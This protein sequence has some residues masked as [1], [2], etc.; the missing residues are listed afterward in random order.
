MVNQLRSMSDKVE[1]I[2]RMLDEDRNQIGGPCG[3]SNNL[4]PIH[5]Q[6][7]QLETFRN[8]TLH[9]AR[10]TARDGPQGE[11]DLQT[12]TKWFERLDMVAQEY[13]DWLWAIAGSIVDC[14]RQ[15]NSGTVVRLLKVIE[16]EG[17]EDQKAV[18]LKLLRRMGGH[19]DAASKFR[20]MQGNARVIKNYR[21]KLLDTISTSIKRSFTEAIEREQGDHLA[22]L[23]NLSWIYKDILRIESDV[24]PLFPEDYEIYAFYVKA[25]HKFL[26]ESLQQIVNQAPE[27]SVLLRMH[28]WIKEY[29]S[30]MKELEIPNAWLQPPLLD[31]KSQ[32][33]IEDYVK[34]IV[35]KIDE[36]TVNLM[37][38]E[39][40]DFSARDTP[41]EMEADGMYG[42]Q[43]AVILFQMVNQQVDLAADSG[44]GAV[45]ARVVSESGRVMRSTQT[46]WMRLLDVEYKRQ[47][48]RPQ[49]VPP[50]LVEYVVALANDQLKCADYAE[51]LSTRLEPLVS[52]KYKSVIAEKL[53]EAIDGY[54]DVAKKCTQVLIDL[55]FNDLKTVQKSLFTQAWYTDTLVE[56][57]V[58]TMR[59]YMSDY[60]GHLNSSIFDLLVEDLIVNFLTIYLNALRRVP[61]K[62]LRMP[63]A[64]VRIKKDVEIAFNFFSSIKASAD[65]QQDF[66]VL[67]MIVAMLSASSHMIFMDFWQFAKKYGPNMPFIEAILRGRDDLDKATT[68]EAIDTLRRKIREEGLTDPPEPTIMVSC[69]LSCVGAPG[70]IR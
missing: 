29:R 6:L 54:L 46:E 22:F 61:P 20:S 42:M 43:G 63:G 58:E 13:E 68:N 24:V 51:A 34:L 7:Q 53:N 1:D 5:F 49:D 59:D 15:G 28:A 45:L 48:E 67:D 44:Q 69:R 27:A 52:D 26:N 18:A 55:V 39:T 31:G 40:R 64:V 50:G 56:Q 11:Q 23:E 37:K 30:N 38:T 8:E 14:T 16:V 35:T 12:L 70:G 57:I 25:Y 3:P 65:L 62:G 19:S 10:K 21:H 33:L 32:D 66:E 60:Q 36:W 9:Q 2:S 4:L 17:K 41:P 47:V